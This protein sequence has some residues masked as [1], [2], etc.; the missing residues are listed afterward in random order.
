MGRA[1]LLAW[2][3]GIFILSVCFAFAIGAL[4]RRLFGMPSLIHGHQPLLRDGTGV[5]ASFPRE[6][7]ESRE[8]RESREF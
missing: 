2:C 7:R 1:R 6:P 4:A 3:L 8:S 5:E